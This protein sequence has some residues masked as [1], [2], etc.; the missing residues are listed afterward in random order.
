M[1]FTNKDNSPVLAESTLGVLKGD[2]LMENFESIKRYSDY[3]NFFEVTDFSFSVAL[4]P[5]DEGVGALSQHASQANSGGGG[6]R[7]PAAND[8]FS[9]WRSAKNDEYKKI[10]FPIEFDVFNFERVIDG[11]SPLFFSACC[12][13]ESFKSAVLVKRVSTGLHGGGERQSEGF[14]RLE[15]RDVFL[16]GIDWD[17]GDL[18]KEKITF[19]CKAMRMRY[20]QQTMAGGFGAEIETIWDQDKDGTSNTS[21]TT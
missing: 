2:P 9:R 13:Q 1:M 5:Q 3:S 19:I 7:A 18:V 10:R 14:L 21:K 4:K 12:N 15:F 11:A 16:T 8:Q 17:D 20:R 6:G